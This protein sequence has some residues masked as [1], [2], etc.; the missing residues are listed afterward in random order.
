MKWNKKIVAK[1]FLQ[2]SFVT[3]LIVTIW[4]KTLNQGL[5]GDGFYWFDPFIAN[6]NIFPINLD[7]TYY[8][9]LSRKIFQTIIPIFRDN[10]QYYQLLQ[11]IFLILLVISIYLVV[12][13][14]TKRTII[15]LSTCIIFISNYGGMYEMIAEGNLNRF[16]ERI[17]NLILLILGIYFLVNFLET[18]KT[19]DFLRSWVLFVIGVYLGQFGSF[20]LPFYIFL[21]IIYLFNIKNP[22][23]SCIA[24]I[25]IAL[26]FAIPNF[27]IIRN[28]DQRSGYPL[29]FYLNP[30]QR[31]IQ[32][33][34]LMI[35]PLIVPQEIVINVANK[36]PW[37]LIPNPYV[38]LVAFYT[39]I[40]TLISLLIGLF[41]L[42]KNKLFFK[43]YIASIF[44][45]LT[46]NALMIYTDPI[47]YD[48]FKNFQAGRPVFVQS[49]FYALILSMVLITFLEKRKIFNRALIAF[50][51]IFVIYNTNLSWRQISANQYLYEGN[52]KYFAYL[53]SISPNFNSDTI[54]VV[55]STLNHASEFINDFNTPKVTFV[56]APEDIKA[57]VNKNN[58][59]NTFVID[60]NYN[61][62]P[63][64]YYFPERVKI[65]DFTNLYRKTKLDLVSTWG[66]Q[67]ITWFESLDIQK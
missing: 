37:G 56:S 40:L 46:E 49:I 3:F 18:K 61:P 13:K 17:P 9:V 25:T 45:M 20:I 53:K 24:G 51:T 55:G 57:S 32:K 11:I 14:L 65:D 30:S 19:K 31:F 21:P 52:N 50:L 36:W 60:V 29:S 59:N 42:R 38:P 23:K 48:P 66:T 22:I 64:G 7:K 6:I 2:L 44:T 62:T 63:D 27:L 8:N 4:F 10:M 47:K 58:I 5:W 28:S 1:I 15:A 33:V 34:F 67:K 41:L 12:L 54:V 16:L 26:S 39:I 43:I 35:T